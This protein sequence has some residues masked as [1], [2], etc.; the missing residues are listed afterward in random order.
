[1]KKSLLLLLMCGFCATSV[2]QDLNTIPEAPEAPDVRD[3]PVVADLGGSILKPDGTVF[4]VYPAQVTLVGQWCDIALWKGPFS[5]TEY[6]SFRVTLQRAP[7]EDGLVQLFARNIVS[8]Q[9]YKG[10]YIPF[11]K[12]QRVLEGD[13]ADYDDDEHSGGWF[14]DDPICTWF[15]LQ[16]TNKGAD[17]QTFTVMEAVLVNE[18]GEEIKSCNVRNGSWKPAPGWVEPEPLMEA[19]VLFT[20]KG[21][22]GLYDS[23]VKPRTI[24]RFTFNT[25]EPM[26]EG[27][28]FYVVIN[29]GDG[30]TYD[31]PVPAGTTSFTTPDI[32][33]EYLRCYLE[34]EGS[35]PMKIHFTKITREVLDVS[36]VED[37]V[38]MRNVERREVFSPAG[39][40]ST[41]RHH[42]L[43]IVRDR[44]SD[45]TLRVRKVIY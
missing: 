17:S 33:D 8:S 12:N 21:V 24:H 11:K 15:A 2:A 44:M 29:D 31:Y 13:F 3:M 43:N 9:N 28:T 32:D 30:S 27:L 39:V 5:I 42:G 36:S 37:A 19:D 25:R 45:G 40:R 4:T 23:K 34:Y 6:P 10:P 38:T 20:N 7:E 35:Y 22:V 1:M 41:I 26:P 14:D 16:K 18:D